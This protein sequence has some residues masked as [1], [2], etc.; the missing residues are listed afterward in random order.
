MSGP[1]HH[2][3]ASGNF[4]KPKTR[5]SARLS[6]VFSFQEAPG[7]IGQ[8]PNSGWRFVDLGDTAS[9]CQCSQIATG[10]CWIDPEQPRSCS[11]K[12]RKPLTQQYVLRAGKAPMR[13]STRTVSA[14]A[15]VDNHAP[16]DHARSGNV[17]SA[18]SGGV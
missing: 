8:A 2:D 5:V 17:Q 14:S 11:L 15:S 7:G 18:S 4:L 10:T 1:G 12:L 9:E 3:I 6:R 13:Y 16:T